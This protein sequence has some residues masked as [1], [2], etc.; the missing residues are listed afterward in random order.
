MLTTKSRRLVQA[1]LIYHRPHAAHG[2]TVTSDKPLKV[3]WLWWE[4]GDKSVLN[5]SAK[6]TKPDLVS[7]QETAKP[8]ADAVPVPAVR[9]Q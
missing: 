7:K 4:E 5:Q 9:R 3:V 6:M 8:M 2:R 1:I